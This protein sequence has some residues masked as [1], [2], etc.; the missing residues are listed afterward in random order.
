[1][2]AVAAATIMHMT[3]GTQ[4]AAAEEGEQ[5]IYFQLW[6][7]GR[8]C[9]SNSGCREAAIDYL[10]NSSSLAFQPSEAAIF[11]TIG[12][13]A[14]NSDAVDLTR[15][16]YLEGKNFTQVSGACRGVGVGAS[17]SNSDAVSLTLRPEFTVLKQDSGCLSK[18][19]ALSRAHAFAVALVKPPK[20]SGTFGG[21]V[22]GCEGG[23]C[24]VAASMPEQGGGVAEGAAAGQIAR[25]CGEARHHCTIGLGDFGTSPAASGPWKQLIGDTG[26]QKLFVNGVERANMVSNLPG[27][28]KG[29][30]V[31]Q[32]F[33]LRK[34]YG[35]GTAGGSVSAAIL[36]DQLIPCQFPGS[37]G[38]DG[39]MK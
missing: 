32:G 4:V 5:R 23:I 30:D 19:G 29:M 33:P 8:K 12:L 39:C 37:F 11:A 14:E 3:T 16:N 26:S 6:N 13:V 24:M 2:L 25:V 38:N 10:T 22:K 20:V 15:Y 36:M 35:N 9:S 34:Q 28:G 17:N 1:M 31:Q 21:I 27:L 7:V 18:K